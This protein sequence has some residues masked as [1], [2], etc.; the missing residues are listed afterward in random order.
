MSVTGPSE[1]A[2]RRLKAALGSLLNTQQQSDAQRR[3]V[4][5]MIPE[6][7]RFSPVA[8][9]TTCVPPA[10]TA[11]RRN[12]P[13]LRTCISTLACAGCVLFIQE[14]GGVSLVPP[15]TSPVFQPALILISHRTAKLT[16][17]LKMLHPR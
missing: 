17:P 5:T 7:D 13:L 6:P 10:G 9:K 11:C 12:S 8:E 15:F 3:S 16:V 1:A 2:V 14:K 4:L